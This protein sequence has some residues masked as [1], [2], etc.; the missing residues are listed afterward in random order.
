MII[1]YKNSAPTNEV[2]E[3]ITT[4]KKECSQI[5]IV[6]G[7]NTSLICL[8]GNSKNV[9]ET[10]VYVYPWVLNV[11]RVS[12]P[13]KL[14]SREYKKED[15]IIDIKGVQIG[16]NKVVMIAGPCSIESKES[17]DKIASSLKKNKVDFL[18]GGA[19]KMRTSPYSFQGLGDV[20]LDY[21]KDASDKYKMISVCEI[22]SVNDLDKYLDKVDIIQ[23]GAR[24][25]QNFDLL[26]AL[27]K[28]NKPILL[29]RGM[30]ASIEELLLS[31]EYILKEGNPNVILCE[32]GIK[33]FEKATRNTLDL[34][35]V[36]VL[37]KL[38][39]LP[40]I[41]DPSH[42][43]GRKEYVMPMALASIACG[44]DGVMIEVHDDPTCARSDAC[45]ALNI[46]EYQQLLE[47]ARQIANVLGRSL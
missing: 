2:S 34:S 31:A 15:T 45:Q 38:T 1:T 36:A 9:D 35:A 16:A 25:M 4:L 14:A 6:K 37:K 7:E 46:E 8:I 23:V 26:K 5:E 43:T 42:S 29:K 30:A 33:T 28:T 20:A 3:L 32:R 39:H 24:N 47:K 22:V 19:Y 18:R 11:A 13:Y 12:T 41:V 40:V 27:G 21:L 10:Q 17:I 44:A